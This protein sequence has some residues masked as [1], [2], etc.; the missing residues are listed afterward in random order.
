M[1]HWFDRWG[2]YDITTRHILRLTLRVRA[3]RSTITA[4]HGTI[5]RNRFALVTLVGKSWVDYTSAE[6]DESSPFGPLA[7]KLQVSETEEE[8]SHSANSKA[9]LATQA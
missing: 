9:C 3:S 1:W 7:Q 6:A 8:A 2:Q 5:Q 4:L